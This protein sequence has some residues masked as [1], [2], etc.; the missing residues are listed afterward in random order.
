MTGESNTALSYLRIL[1]IDIFNKTY[2][3][4]NY[5]SFYRA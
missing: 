4:H 2:K 1:L 3:D 5:D